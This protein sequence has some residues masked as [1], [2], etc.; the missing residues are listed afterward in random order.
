[1]LA[2][3]RIG[4]GQSQNPGTQFELTT[5][6]QVPEPLPAASPTGELGLILAPV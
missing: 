3:A 5:Q 2:A 1:M 6:T 4:T